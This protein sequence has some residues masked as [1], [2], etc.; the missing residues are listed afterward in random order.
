M[1]INMS[2]FYYE[3][4]PPFEEAGIRVIAV[5]CSDGRFAGATEDFLE[6]G[7][8]LSHCDRLVLPGGPA[9]LVEHEESSLDAGAVLAALQFLVEAHGLRRVLLI[10]HADCGFYQHQL[11]LTGP[12]L[13]DRQRRD[14]VAAVEA[15]KRATGAPQIDCFYAGPA[16]G[17]VVF[18]SIAVEQPA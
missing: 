10:Q 17:H 8:A 13:R 1:A 11:G 9:A 14:L 16:D 5:F 6:H 3:S 7:L 18:R 2:G 12:R 4:R 15:V